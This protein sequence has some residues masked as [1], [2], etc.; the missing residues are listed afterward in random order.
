M[1]LTT[2][3]VT[4]PEKNQVR[5]RLGHLLFEK[6]KILFNDM[7]YSNAARILDESMRY[8]LT[9]VSHFLGFFS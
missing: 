7:M 3:E 5:A 2:T 4:K 8:H 1:E 9:K 6:S